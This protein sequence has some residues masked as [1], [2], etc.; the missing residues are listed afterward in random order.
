VTPYIIH[1][2]NPATLYFG[3]KDIY[4]TVNRFNTWTNYSTNLTINDNVGGGML[5]SMAISESNPDSVLYAASYVVVYRTID[6]GA[7][8]QDVTSNL[9]TS[10]GCFNCS[11]LSDIA[12]HHSNPDVAWVT[13][14]GYSS[15]KVFKTTDGGASWANV[16]GT[17]PAVPVNCIVSENNNDEGLYI[18]TDIG[19]FYRDSSMSDWVPFMTGLPNVPVQELEIQYGTGTIR[20]AT[21]GR[22]LWESDLYGINTSDNSAVQNAPG[23]SVQ[24]N[25]SDGVFTVMLKNISAPSELSIYNILGENILRMPINSNAF[26]IDLSKT[27][28]GIYLLCVESE[29]SVLMQKLVVAK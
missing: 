29:Q 26:D 20:A 17:L 2:A 15:N 19:V 11:A 4:R 9:P 7:T 27:N 13:M 8:W 21:F 3:A 6:G 23:F 18:G 28:G 14:S 22:G 24:P 16:S 12:I 1:P 5:R 25:P 10:A